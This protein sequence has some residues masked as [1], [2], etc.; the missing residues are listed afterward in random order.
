MLLDGCLLCM[1]SKNLVRILAQAILPILAV[2]QGVTTRTSGANG[3]FVNISTRA[4]VGTGDEVMIG[5]FIIGNGPKM[6]LV[7]ARGPELANA[8]V[9]NFLADP[10]LKITTMDGLE[11]MANDNWEDSQRRLISD[12]WKGSPPMTTGSLSSAAVLFLDPGNYTAKVEGKNETTGVALV[13]MYG[14]DL[15]DVRVRDLI[16]LWAL[17]NATDGANWVDQTNW[18]TD[19]PLDQWYGIEVD[20]EGRVIGLKLDAN[21][22]SGPIPP[23]LGLLANLESLWLENNQLN[24]PIPPEL[25]QLDR[26]T[27]LRI[28]GNPLVGGIPESLSLLPLRELHFADTELCAPAA[29]E[30]RMW[31]NA[32]PSHRG[33]GVEC[34]LS[35]RE[36]LAILYEATGGPNWLISEN[37]LTDAPLDQWHGIEVD[38]TGSVATIYLARNNLAGRIP[39]EV[40]LLGELIILDLSYNN[41][42]GAIPPEIGK[43]ENLMI[44]QAWGNFL[45]G[46]IPPEIGRLADLWILNFTE[47]NLS[48][49][50]PPGLGQLAELEVLEFRYNNLTGT[51][52]PELGSATMLERLELDNNRLEGSLPENLFSLSGLHRLDLSNNMFSGT[53]PS[54]LG[55]LDHLQELRLANNMFS[56]ALPPSLGQLDHLQELHLANNMFSG[57]VPSE[58]GDLEELER[59]YLHGNPELSGHLPRNLVS[60]SVTRLIADR[61]GLCAP[62]EPLFGDWLASLEVARVGLCGWLD[63]PAYLMQAAQSREYPV[64]LVAGEDALLR[65]FVTSGQQTSETLP[66]VRATFFVDGS[67]VHVEEIPTSS[68]VIP[69]EVHEGKLD[70]SANALIPGSVIKPGLE[71]VVE[72]DPGETVDPKLSV[73]KRYPTEGRKA[74]DV[75]VIPPLNL[76]L[77]PFIWMG[78]NNRAT[79]ELVEELHP[80]HELF[81]ETKNLLPVDTLNITKHEPVLVDANDPFDLLVMTDQIR[82]AEGGEGHWMGLLLH[83]AAAPGV[84]IAFVRGKASFVQPYPNSGPT[85]AHELGHNF[86]LDHAPCDVLADLDPLFPD[87][88]G[89]TGTWGYDPREGGSLVPPDY[90]DLM[91]YCHPSWIGE[92]NFSKAFNFRIVDEV[93]P[94]SPT[95]VA[96]KSLLVSGRVEA[97]STL[98]LD[99][100]FAIL[101]PPVLPEAPGPYALTGRRAD[102]SELFSVA[103]DVTEVACGNGS[104]SFTFALPVSAAWELELARLVLSGPGGAV[105]VLQGSES[106]KVIACDS[107][108]GEVRAIL[109]N[110]SDLS[111]EPTDQNILKAI[112]FEPGLNLMVSSGLPFAPDWRQ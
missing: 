93:V 22:L 65:V 46:G 29:A 87:P 108:T 37:W 35:E 7:Q 21:Q 62:D 27:S 44:L 30:F 63:V 6:V 96:A 67:D 70:L 92:Y 20:G 19:A 104:A 74:L 4:L 53:L 95:V 64:P 94:A 11:L 48:G 8:G 41:L 66:A 82:I 13:E 54:G 36:I 26:M 23:E 60:G 91:S 103:F 86:S 33:T 83:D 80:D 102:G 32:L 55:R 97:D 31:L 12:L 90:P 49:E 100:A 17:Y 16:A 47:N 52:P 51:I 73:S 99:P 18:L 28:G 109:S 15:P 111:V 105:E 77:V 85:I 59:L 1:T 34:P 3:K 110:F 24:G 42:E 78:S 79:A 43:L 56:G 112:A 89:Q 38:G 45:T 68:S 25:G 10:V 40:G 5:G 106:T 81:W 14:I 107:R 39:P 71:M 57:G 61:T 98:H 50:I 76:T 72:I 84:A 2:L 58:L 75:R 88:D 101:A 9:S 69:T